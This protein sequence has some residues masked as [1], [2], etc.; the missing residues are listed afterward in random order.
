[1]IAGCPGLCVN[2]IIELLVDRAVHSASSEEES[3]ER[4]DSGG[5]STGERVESNGINSVRGASADMLGDILIHD[6]DGHRTNLVVPSLNTLAADPSV[7]VRS[8]V[9][10]LI[11]ACLRHARPAA[12]EAF[13]ILV[14]ADDRLLATRR[15][16]DLVVYVGW[17]NSGTIQPVITRMLASTFPEVR[18]VGG[19][20]A[21]FA[22][23]EWGL[24]D[25]LETARTSADSATREGVASVCALR[26]PR[27]SNA[28]IAGATLRQLSGDADEKV[29]DAV[30]EVAGALRGKELGPFRDVLI[31]LV[32]SPSFE[33]AVDQ[34]LI[35]LERATDR[36]DDLIIACARR[37]I[38]VFGVDMGNLSTGAAG[39]ADE[40][41]R[42]VLRAY[43]QA[44]TR[45]E[46]S[47]VLD[48]IDKLLLFSAYRVD[49]LVD[50]AER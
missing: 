9:A 20:L 8:C 1:M 31:S 30:A 32:G 27:T 44:R 49:E 18:K 43:E 39:N 3:W 33:P 12:L 48:L 35:T 7:A 21:A 50:A 29:R 19:Q 26:L 23:L 40:V 5:R 47:A 4:S 38:E 2:D 14:Q 46:R 11:A 17:G 16:A 34:L 36:I 41:G 45:L 37:F 28:T 42:L 10:H 13:E 25:L 6:I 15:V 22:G 24:A